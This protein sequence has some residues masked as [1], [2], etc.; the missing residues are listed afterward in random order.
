MSLAISSDTIGETAQTI[1]LTAN[2]IFAPPWTNIIT[3]GGYY[4]DNGSAISALIAGAEAD[5]GIILTLGNFANHVWQ[6]ANDGVTWENISGNFSGYYNQTISAFGLAFNNFFVAGYIDGVVQVCGINPGECTTSIPPQSWAV[7]SEV[8]VTPA[9]GSVSFANV[10]DGSSGQL[11]ISDDVGGINIIPGITAGVGRLAIDGVFGNA[12]NLY[13]PLSN[14]QIVK[15][16]DPWVAVTGDITPNNFI[17]NEYA[18][19]M[20][21]DLNTNILYAG[22]NFANVYMSNKPI[23]SNSWIRLTATPLS[24]T[25]YI[26]SIATNFKGDVYAGL[27]TYG[28]KLSG[29]GIYILPNGES[30]FIMAGQSYNDQSAI[31]NIIFDALVT[32]SMYVGTYLGNIWRQ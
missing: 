17:N 30:N 14:G 15:I 31:T 20:F 27:S 1:N 23:S 10:T 25:S 19:V 29:G 5:G 11:L 26:S 4:T 13:V 12:T 21:Y 16:N 9:R 6:L 2:S 24:N 22:T 32:E 8:N 3:S 18:N 7:T 28:N